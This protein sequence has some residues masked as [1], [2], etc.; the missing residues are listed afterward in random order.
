MP[1]DESSLMSS[2]GRVFGLPNVAP[3]ALAAFSPFLVLS[4]R[5]S[6]SAWF[7]A[8]KIERK[9]LPIAELV[10]IFSESDIS[11]TGVAPV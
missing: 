5:I 10:S 9:H 11:S 2:P 6:L 4:L 7:K 8:P 3:R 1:F